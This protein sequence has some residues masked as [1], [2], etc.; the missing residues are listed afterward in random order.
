MF[1]CITVKF[2]LK[3]FCS[4]FDRA[5]TTAGRFLFARSFMIITSVLFLFVFCLLTS[6]S[7]ASLITVARRARATFLSRLAKAQ[8]RHLYI[9]GA[10][11]CCQNGLARLIVNKKKSLC[12]F[13]S[14]CNVLLVI[15]V[16]IVGYAA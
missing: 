10:F 13:G 7:G 9:R 14:F 12:Y 4:C 2:F 3:I 15:F 6:S 16:F 1:F 8:V 5:L 11:S